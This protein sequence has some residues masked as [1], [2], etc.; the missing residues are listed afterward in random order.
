MIG[1][2]KGIPMV[3]GGEWN[4]IPNI[5]MGIPYFKFTLKVIM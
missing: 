1:I 3:V 2:R 4:A 5:F